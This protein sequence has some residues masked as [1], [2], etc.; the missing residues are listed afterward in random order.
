MSCIG[1]N[2]KKIRTVKN[3][4]QAGFAQLFDLA[5]PSVGAYEEGRS[6]PKIETLVQI[7]RHFGVSLDLMITKELT[8]NDLYGFD[9]FK[10]DLPQSQLLKKVAE[11]SISASSTVLVTAQALPAYLSQGQDAT[12]LQSLPVIQLPS[13]VQTLHR[14]FEHTGLEMEYQ[15]QGILEGDVLY[16]ASVPLNAH[17]LQPQAVYV[18]VTATQIVTRRYQGL[19]HHNE[20]FLKADNPAYEVALVPMGDVKELWQVQGV[21]STRLTL[22]TPIETRLAKLEH[23]VQ[24]LQLQKKAE[25]A[26]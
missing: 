5:R 18:V 24:E 10:R 13:Q 12:F 14:A 22:P 4:S 21:Y 8:I 17:L 23:Q 9:I 15:Q 1:K 20:L 19:S 3:L 11:P 6:E 26:K 2:I 16:A 7:A 25:Q